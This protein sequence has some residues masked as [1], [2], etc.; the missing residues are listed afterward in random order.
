MQPHKFCPRCGQPCVL[1]MRF[2]GRC[3]FALTSVQRPTASLRQNPAIRRAGFVLI[4]ALAC[5][6]AYRFT[7]HQILRASGTPVFLGYTTQ[8][9]VAVARTKQDAQYY[10][11]PTGVVEAF[12]I[13][14]GGSG[15]DNPYHTENVAATEREQQKMRDENRVFEVPGGTPAIRLQIEGGWEEVEIEDGEYSGSIGWVGSFQVHEQQ[16]KEPPPPYPPVG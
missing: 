14:G 5:T 3:G 2:C 8:D 9:G 11:N 6:F 7:K 15:W 16:T 13:G 12:V 10:F 1:S 4:A